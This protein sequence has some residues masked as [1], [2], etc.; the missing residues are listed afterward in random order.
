M[1][2]SI[3]EFVSDFASAIKH[4]DSK[5]PVALNAR[6]KEPYQPGIGPHPEGQTVDLVIEEL[7][8]MFPPKYSN[9]LAIGVIYNS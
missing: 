8:T 4:V 6:S 1:I 9:K 2:T 3:S 5:K 7:R